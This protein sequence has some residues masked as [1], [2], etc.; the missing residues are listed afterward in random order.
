MIR[1]NIIN[2]LRKNIPCSFWNFAWWVPSSLAIVLLPIGVL[3][4]EAI[5]KIGFAEPRGEQL[6]FVISIFYGVGIG[7][8]TL[9]LANKAELSV[10]LLQKVKW[11]ARFAIVTPFLTLLFL[12]WVFSRP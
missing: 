11:L 1:Q 3:F 4:F 12:F 6:L 10:Q 9:L 7:V 5:A 8:A 2:W